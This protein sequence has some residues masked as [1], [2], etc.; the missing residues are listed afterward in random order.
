MAYVSDTGTPGMYKYEPWYYRVS[1]GGIFAGT[2]VALGNQLLW[3]LL[4]MGIGLGIISPAAE[5][6]EGV[7]IGT[8]I[9]VLLVTLVSLFVGGWVACRISGITDKLKSALHGLV[10]WA[11]FTFTAFYIM[12]TAAGGLISSFAGIIGRSAAIAAGEIPGITPEMAQTALDAASR[13]SLWGFFALLLSAVA[14]VLG[15]WVGRSKEVTTIGAAA[16]EER[17]RGRRAA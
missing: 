10:V 11:L 15:G 7:G 12:T 9:Y 5:G 8:G 16:A 13:A 3:M 14:A 6:L 1:W 2:L 17:E 4:G